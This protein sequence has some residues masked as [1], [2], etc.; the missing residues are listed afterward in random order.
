[1]IPPELREQIEGELIQARLARREGN[2]GMARVCARRAAGWAAG[3]FFESQLG[4]PPT[5]NAYLLL[6]KLKNHSDIPLQLREAASRLTTRITITHEIP[7][8][9]DPIEDARMIV[10]ALLDSKGD[11]LGGHSPNAIG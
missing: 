7:F 4:D 3:Y 10:Q 11:S 8:K 2:E 6:K 5:P 9:E 1:M